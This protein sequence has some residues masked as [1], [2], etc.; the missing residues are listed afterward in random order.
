MNKLRDVVLEQRKKRKR[1]LRVVKVDL[2]KKKRSI[3]AKDFFKERKW[4]KW[5]IL[6]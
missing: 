4:S 2:Y 3:R 1:V 6:W 5:Y